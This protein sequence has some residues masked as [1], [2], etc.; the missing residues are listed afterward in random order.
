M[1]GHGSK[2]ACYWATHLDGRS[3][4]PSAARPEGRPPF[5]IQRLADDGGPTEDIVYFDASASSVTLRGV[6]IAADLLERVKL[7]P[8]GRGQYLSEDGEAVEPF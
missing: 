6:Q 1:T 3:R 8:E 5:S 2:R 7:L 4:A